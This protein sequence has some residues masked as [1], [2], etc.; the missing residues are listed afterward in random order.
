[1]RKKEL[2]A[3]CEVLGISD[4]ELLGYHDSGMEGW[5]ENSAAGAF[6]TTPVDAAAARL[7]ALFERYRPQ[8]VITYDEHG[9]YATPTT[10]KPT[11]SP[12]LPWG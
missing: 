6:W 2:E 3:S 11:A 8:V 1:V 4:L 5:P 7:A 10:C 12:W 9:L